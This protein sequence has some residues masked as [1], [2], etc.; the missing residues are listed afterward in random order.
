MEAAR[1]ALVGV[2][3]P[4]TLVF[5]TSAPAYQDKTNA[6]A[7]HAALSLPT[8]V[9]AYDMVGS[10]RSAV[11]ALAGA[12]DGCRD[13]RSTLVVLSDVRTGLAGGADESDGGDGAA[14]L[15]CGASGVLADFVA[16][17]SATSELLDR[18]REPGGQTSRVWEERFGESVYVP[19]AVEAA[20]EACKQADVDIGEIAHIVVVGPHARSNRAAAKALGVHPKIIIDDL[21]SS[22]GNTGCAHLG[23][24][25]ADAL[26]RAEPHDH[27]L[28]VSIGDGADAMLFTATDLLP[29]Y[30]KDRPAVR[31]AARPSGKLPV[32]YANFLTWRGMLRREPPRRPDPPRP[33]A[34]PAHRNERW[35][36]G[37]QGSGCVACGTRHLPPTRVCQSCAAADEMEP[38]PFADVQATITTFTVDRLAYSMNPP[39]VVV[40]IDFDGGG[41]FQCELT[42][43]DVT[44]VRIGD[45]V[46]MTFRR[47]FTA[48]GV[49]N[50][51][52][53]ARPV[54]ARTEGAD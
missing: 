22:I 18:W 20:S 54:A 30:R 34:P 27:I 45:R 23:V 46:E 47:L 21:G 13:D 26:D 1:H 33:A 44:E 11:G 6:T 4:D 38:V 14:A 41:R 37:F 29:D 24:L 16:K 32:D 40:V 39:A 19:L 49:H 17:A 5:A 8:S 15:G 7:I 35:K 9:A 43:V 53:K 3:A 50:Y 12:L 31:L 51:F 2:A 52:W 10:S 28:V 36:F 48:D 25:L 42:D